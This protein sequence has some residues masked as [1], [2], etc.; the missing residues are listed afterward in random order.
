MCI[1]N[2][3]D[4]GLEERAGPEGQQRE[5]KTKKEIY[6][7]RACAFGSFSYFHA[8]CVL[9]ACALPKWACFGRGL[10]A[11]LRTCTVS[12]YLPKIWALLFRRAHDVARGAD[13]PPRGAAVAD[14]AAAAVVVVDDDDVGVA[15]ASDASFR[16]GMG[17]SMR[18]LAANTWSPCNPEVCL[19]F[20]F[21]P[22][23]WWWVIGQSMVD[24]RCWCDSDTASPNACVVRPHATQTTQLPMRV[25]TRHT[26][27]PF[28]HSPG[29]P[30]PPSVA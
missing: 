4:L 19:S 18:S 3:F 13:A 1:C 21:V 20:R 23:R 14:A 11:Y 2:I 17:T 10:I 5:H 22:F 30:S 26:T 15:A 24:G 6:N 25:S 9:L 16:A 29:E 27:H 28:M 8:P 12:R 7:L